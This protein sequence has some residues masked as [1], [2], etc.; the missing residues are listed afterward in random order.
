MSSTSTIS[1]DRSTPS[2]SIRGVIALLSP[3]VLTPRIQNSALAPGS[4]VRCIATTPASFP[5]RP[6]DS[7]P[8]GAFSWSAS[9]VVMEP[10]TEAFF[11]V[12]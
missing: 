8:M 4:P 2:T 7:W 1:I 11:W 9:T 12:P 6:V 10:M 3:K 5:A